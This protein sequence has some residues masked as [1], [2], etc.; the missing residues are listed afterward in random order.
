[1]QSFSLRLYIKQIVTVFPIS[2]IF[3]YEKIKIFV[4]FWPYRTY[5]IDLKFLI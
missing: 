4:S 1:M 5:F 3:G 2:S